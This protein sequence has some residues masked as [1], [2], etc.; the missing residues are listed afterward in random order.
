MLYV[1]MLVNICYVEI[2]RLCWFQFHADV[3]VVFVVVFSSLLVTDGL[4]RLASR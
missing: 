2:G 4:L 3:R 1:N